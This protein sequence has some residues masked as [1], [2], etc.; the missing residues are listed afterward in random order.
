[1]IKNIVKKIFFFFLSL[2]F[3][4]LIIFFCVE[5]LPGDVAQIILGTEANLQNLQILRKELGLDA[6]WYIRYFFWIG[7]LLQADL[8][9][10]YVLEENNIRLFQE[11]IAITISLIFGSIAFSLT[12]AYIIGLTSFFTKKKF[13]KQNIISFLQIGAA[14]PSFWIATLLIIFFAVKNQW[15]PAGSFPGWN[16]NSWLGFSHSAKYLF[17]P[18]LSLSIPQIAIFT[19]VIKNSLQATKNEYFIKT[20]ISKGISKQKVLLFHIF[21]YSQIPIITVTALQIPFLFTGA[22]LIENIFYL[23]GI[24]RLILQSIYQRDLIL[25]KNAILLLFILVIFVQFLAKILIDFLNP[26]EKKI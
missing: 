20:A 7:D 21:P 23:P 19:R 17:L 1:M 10:S 15:L 8:G 16:F 24:G 3:A 2:F 6:S 13:F 18:I 25:L 26:E 11:R 12:I 5:I 14:L 4:S 9:K 22:V